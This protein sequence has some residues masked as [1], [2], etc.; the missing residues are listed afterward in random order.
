MLHMTD[1]EVRLPDA[2]ARASAARRGAKPMAEVSCILE[3]GR[4]REIVV[5]VRVGRVLDAGA[6]GLPRPEDEAFDVIHDLEGRV[7]FTMLTEMLSRRD[8]AEGEARDKLLRYGFRSEEI[9]QAIARARDMRFLNDERFASYFIEE[10]KR[11]GCGRRRIERELAQRGIALDELE[12][13]PEDFFSEDDDLARAREVLARKRVPE[14]RG[15]EKL[16]RHLMAK[17]FSYGVA[18]EAVRDRL[19]SEETGAE[20]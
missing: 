12:G 2:A 13:Y 20:D 14:Q 19:A 7:C 8:H 6:I 5:P 1:V 17:G 16:V 4:S 10:R 3:D 18:A 11:R 15:F 9:E